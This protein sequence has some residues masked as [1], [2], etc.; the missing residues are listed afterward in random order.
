M[1]LA[2]A[3]AGLVA[4]LPLGSSGAGGAKPKPITGATVVAIQSW[5]Q[6]VKTHTPGRA[7]GPVVAVA[8]LTYEAREELNAGMAIFL[9]ALLT[10]TYNTGRNP[11]AKAIVDIGHGAGNPGAND[12][13]KQAAIL[14]ADVAA[15]GDRFPVRPTG[16]AEAARSRTEQVQIGA[17]GITRIERDEPVSPLLTNNRLILHDDG[18]VLG[19]V[20]ASWNWPFARSL[21]DLVDAGPW[22]KLV[23][24]EPRPKPA[25]DPVVSAWYHATTA[26]MFAIGSYGDATPHL[27]HAADV[28]PDDAWVL[29]DRGC[30]AE[31]LGLPLH[32]ALLSERDIASQRADH[33]YGNTPQMWTP[34]STPA[35][36]L[37]ST[38]KTNAEAERLY[39]RALEIDPSL[40]EARV[41]LGRLLDLRKRHE[42]AAA[43]LKTALA[44][45]PSGAVAYYAHLFAG[46][47]AQAMG[48]TNEAARHYQDAAALFPDAQSALLASSQLALLGA[49][50]ASA[51]APVQRL[52]ARSAAF[53]AD[54][55]WQYHLGAGRDADDLLKALWASVAR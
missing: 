22:E 3:V 54:P 44:G 1:R 29:F 13:L 12:Y 39:R 55:W 41:R 2:A 11:A 37:P 16:V 23:P 18:Q 6:A 42:E 21:L 24:G 20:V 15:Y 4:S 33:R 36:R 31:I 14:H 30:Y 52:G 17:L 19:E 8:A 38:E 5:V 48:Q 26:Y 27:Q 45:N 40:V 25:T 7:D 43:E 47:A 53:T 51:L 32:Q 50:V 9:R 10:R 28:L 46:R 34:G 35:L 49:D